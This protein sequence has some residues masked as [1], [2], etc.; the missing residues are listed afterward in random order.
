MKLK[1]KNIGLVAMVLLFSLFLFGNSYADSITTPLNNSILH[2]GQNYNFTIDINSITNITTS[3]TAMLIIN[4]SIVYQNSFTAN[5]LYHVPIQFNNYG[6]YNISLLTTTSKIIDLN[7]SIPQPQFHTEF[8]EL[9]TYLSYYFVSLLILAIAFIFYY[10]IDRYEK[11]SIIANLILTIG[12]I[13]VFITLIL[14]YSTAI[15][16]FIY[17]L[18]VIGIGV[19]AL[20]SS[21]K[22]LFSAI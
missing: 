19:L 17:Y 20:I 10:F 14:N 5:G 21:F 11:Q 16:I 9:N 12:S 22:I 1:I 18:S 8:A 6:N 2:I 15:N 3:D 7:V 13:A 4:N